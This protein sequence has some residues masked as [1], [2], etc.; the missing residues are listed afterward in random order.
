MAIYS[1]LDSSRK[2]ENFGLAPAAQFNLFDGVGSAGFYVPTA[3]EMPVKR[4]A[5]AGAA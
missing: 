4:G 3:K 1:R 2:P 5:E